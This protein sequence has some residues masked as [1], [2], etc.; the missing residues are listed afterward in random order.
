M[1]IQFFEESIC[2]GVG[3]WC[4]LK[5]CIISYWRLLFMLLC[6]SLVLWLMTLQFHLPEYWSSLVFRITLHYILPKYSNSRI[7]NVVLKFRSL[8]N[9]VKIYGNLPKKGSNVHQVC[10]DEP[11]ILLS[12]S[13]IWNFNIYTGDLNGMNRN[14]N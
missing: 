8:G 9:I 14:R 11:E 3:I 6:S 5:L 1:C 7:K 12:L 2:E 10:L 13:Y 4:W